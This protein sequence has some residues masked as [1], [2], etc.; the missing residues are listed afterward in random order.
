[1]DFDGIALPFGY[2]SP[3][4]LRRERLHIDVASGH[5]D[6]LASPEIDNATR[7]DLIEV[8]RTLRQTFPRVRAMQRIPL[9]VFEP[10]AGFEEA[11]DE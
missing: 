10:G 8:Y 3:S 5:I 7:K 11:A 2:F 4:D 9:D 6:P 1:M